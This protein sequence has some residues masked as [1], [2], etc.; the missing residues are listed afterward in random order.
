MRD[1]VATRR[2]ECPN[3]SMCPRLGYN[4]PSSIL[5]VVDFPEPFGPSR[6][7]TSPGRTSK[8][9]LST[10]LALGRPQKSLNTF[11]S[12]RTTTTFSVAGGLFDVR[13]GAFSSRAIIVGKSLKRHVL[14]QGRRPPLLERRREPLESGA[15]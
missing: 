12:P 13:C 15:S 9:T 11:V 4:R 6:P 3:T 8:S 5:T 14:P 7:N 10:A 2:G 1:L